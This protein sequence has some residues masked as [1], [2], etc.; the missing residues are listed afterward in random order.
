M[1]KGA[2][3]LFGLRTDMQFGKLKLQMVASQKKSADKSVSSRG[4]AQFT[5]FEIDV[6]NYEENRHFF[7]HN[8]SVR[9]TM[10]T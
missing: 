5:P 9:P 4:G 10:T 7:C 8:I 2:S 1:I 6:A 3:S